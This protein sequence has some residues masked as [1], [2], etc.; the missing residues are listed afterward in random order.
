MRTDAGFHADQAGWY[1][2]EPRFHLPTRPLLPQHDGAARI[3]AH[4]VERVLADIDAD[5]GDRSI[6]CPRH[7]VLLVFGAPCQ[8]RLLAG[9]EHGR[10]IPLSDIPL[11]PPAT[12]ETSP[13]IRYA[14]DFAVIGR[15]TVKDQKHGPAIVRSVGGVTGPCIGPLIGGGAARYATAR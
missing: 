5:H 4:D 10:T 15:G 7:G 2:G 3:M 11:V 12:F 1:V 9:Q 6:G 13:G 14:D 8:L